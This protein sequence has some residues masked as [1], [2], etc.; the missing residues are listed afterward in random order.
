MVAEVGG[1]EADAQAAALGAVE[2]ERCVLRQVSRVAGVPVAVFGEDRLGREVVAVVQREQQV[3]VARG[4][5][6]PQLQG[7]AIAGFGLRVAALHLQG[8]REIGDPAMLVRRQCDGVAGCL[9]GGD[10]AAGAQIHRAEI[11]VGG[12][13]RG[14][15]GE[16]GLQRLAVPR[17]SVPGRARRRR[18]WCGVRPSAARAAAAAR[19]ASAASASLP[20]RCSTVPSAFERLG[21][22]GPRRQCGTIG[23][24]GVGEAASVAQ[25][26][27]EIVRRS[28]ELR[29]EGDGPAVGCRGFG[30]LA[31][32]AQQSTEVGMVGGVAHHR[33]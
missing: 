33:P 12:G 21:V 17:R 4:I 27:A 25:Q 3:A 10:G 16:R 14:V 6:G 26:V 1:D 19:N 2:I 31:Q 32:G 22:V 23:G 7:V 20:R 28:G 9:L 30:R 15:D 13:M 24:F 29:I 8:H 5:V 11:A 18:D